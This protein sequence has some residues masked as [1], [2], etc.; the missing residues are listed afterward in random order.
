MLDRLV[1]H[2]LMPTVF[3]QQHIEISNVEAVLHDENYIII[4]M[5]DGEFI[6]S[7]KNPFGYTFPDLSKFCNI[8]RTKIHKYNS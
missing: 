1:M 7:I 3:P 4:K 8:L 5:N 6:K 2:L